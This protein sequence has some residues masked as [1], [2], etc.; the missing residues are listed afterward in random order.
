MAIAYCH[1]RG[2]QRDIVLGALPIWKKLMKGSQKQERQSSES[3]YGCRS[4]N[5]TP[6]CVSAAATCT[7]KVSD[8]ARGDSSACEQT[9]GSFAARDAD[10]RYPPESLGLRTAKPLKEDVFGDDCAN[11]YLRSLSSLI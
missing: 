6:I 10:K 1:V 9:A 11:K 8:M 5:S 3:N 2:A 4:P 7:G